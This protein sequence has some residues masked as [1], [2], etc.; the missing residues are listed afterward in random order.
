MNLRQSRGSMDRGRTLT[1]AA[2]LLLAS[3]LAG[4]SRHRE[5]D[6]QK[7]VDDLGA[8]DDTMTSTVR[9]NPNAAGLDQVDA[10]LA[11][12]R[13][14]LH[15]RLLAL[16]TP[17]LEPATS[18]AL[19][20]ACEKNQ[21]AA[22]LVRGYVYNAVLMRDPALRARARK[23]AASLCEVCLEPSWNTRCATFQGQD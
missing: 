18:T 22:D 13:V 14:D 1:R 7:L 6:V 19:G 17:D 2:L 23:T 10:L 8:F 21:T 20:N 4:C 9:L 15:T 11:A 16:D 5:Q 12:K 3:L